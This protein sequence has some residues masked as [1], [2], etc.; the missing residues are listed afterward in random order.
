MHTILPSLLLYALIAVTTFNLVL[1]VPVQHPSLPS[2]SAPIV[3]RALSHSPIPSNRL[4]WIEVVTGGLARRSA[5]TRSFAVNADNAFPYDFPVIAVAKNSMFARLYTPV[6]DNCMFQVFKLD[7]HGNITS[8]HFW[9]NGLEQGDITPPIGN[10]DRMT[11]ACV[12][13]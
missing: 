6:P 1:A 5:S 2:P 11:V 3:P 10:F 12:Q 13:D 4:I 7:E 9:D 8:S